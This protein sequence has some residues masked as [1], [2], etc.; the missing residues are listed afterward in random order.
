MEADVVTKQYYIVG[1]QQYCLIHLTSFSG[2][3]SAESAAR[4]MVDSF[5]W[6]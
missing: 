2:S 4:S 1:E 6:N 5:I 3:E